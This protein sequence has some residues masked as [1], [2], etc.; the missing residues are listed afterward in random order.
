[1]TLIIICGIVAVITGFGGERHRKSAPMQ[2][3]AY[4]ALKPDVAKKLLES[5]G[6]KQDSPSA[7]VFESVQV[8]HA[9]LLSGQVWRLVTP[10]FLHFS[11]IH[12][13]FNMVWLY[14]LGRQ[15]ENRYSTVYFGALV[16]FIA[17]VSNFAQCSVPGGVGGSVPGPIDGS[18]YV[19]TLLGGM[20][21]VVFGL[22]GF[23]WVKSSIDPNCRLFVSPSTIV[24]MLA[25]LVFC[26]TPMA[27]QTILANVANWA[28]GVGMLAGVVAGYCMTIIKK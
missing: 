5:L 15:I 28:H 14:Q 23:I 7:E 6:E 20:S 9:N 24:F 19:M 13:L 4:T 17:V 18:G 21:G 2:A 10:I 27:E 11:V 8:R 25:F 26:M 12:L 22:L 16:L 1:M 3:L